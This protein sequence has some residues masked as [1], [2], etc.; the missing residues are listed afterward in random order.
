MVASARLVHRTNP[1]FHYK[2]EMRISSM[3]QKFAQGINKESLG[4][5]RQPVLQTS[6][7]ARDGIMR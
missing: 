1:P 2:E 6:F 3:E 4:I 5:V 7:I